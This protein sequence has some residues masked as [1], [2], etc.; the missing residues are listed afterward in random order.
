MA[1]KVSFIITLKNQFSATARKVNKSISGIEKKAKSA[2]VKIKLMA[3]AS[4][5]AARKMA[6]SFGKAGAAMTAAITVPIGLM[7]RSMINAASDAD[8]TAAKFN[9]VF[10]DIEGKANKT[11]TKFAKTFGLA[12]STAQEMIGNTGDLL[13]GFGFA[14]Q[15]ALDMAE[16][17]N[18]LALDLARF[19]NLEGGAARASKALTGALSG[20]A[21]ALK[22][23]GIVVNQNSPVFKK[24][25]KLNMR[26]AKGDLVK[27]KAL[28]IL[29]MASDQSR[30][31]TGAF[32]NEAQG[33]PGLQFTA[34]EATKK[35][36]E[37]LGKLLLPFAIKLTKMLI[38]LVE[39][40]DTF[41]PA[42]KKTVL[43]VGA[44]LAIGGPLLLL[45]AGIG[46]AFAFISLL[47]LA[48][49]AAILLVGAAITAVAV[50]WDSIVV[51]MQMSWIS[52]S[53][54]VGGTIEQIGINFSNMWEGVKN[55]LFGFINLAIQG[56]NSLLKPLDLVSRTLG[57]GGVTISQV[58][59][60]TAP[61][62]SG[63]TLDGQ[64]TVSAGPGA[65][66]ESTSMATSG[67]GLNVGMNMAR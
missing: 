30:K 31:A 66:V 3:K 53:D 47:V 32:L 23:M 35:L 65:V 22:S 43:I 50:N 28:T 55:G 20:E 29:K 60:P 46:A 62:Q 24:M 4:Q 57:F 8:E 15:E 40:I 45:L 13:V 56:I 44:L 25:L 48:V 14:G 36:S 41:S 33:L 17:I 5:A 19:Q 39:R 6:A 18:V 7:A 37:S 67:A 34:S 52:F 9:A 64:I 58:G 54:V 21:E 51:S 1:N 42:M 12:N 2:T 38:K 61:T 27:A 49:G 63:G 59:A 26:I 16:K 11:A 10:D